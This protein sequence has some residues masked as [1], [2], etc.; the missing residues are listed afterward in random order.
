MEI[1]I[2]SDTSVLCL[3]HSKLNLYFS[4]VFSWCEQETFT[5]TQESAAASCPDVFQKKNCG[6]PGLDST[7]SLSHMNSTAADSAPTQHPAGFSHRLLCTFHLGTGWRS[8]AE[9]WKVLSRT[10]YI[11]PLKTGG[12]QEFRSDSSFSEGLS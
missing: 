11:S 5:Q 8:S 2:D 1:N 9:T 4:H 12:S 6:E 10:F 7:A 3:S